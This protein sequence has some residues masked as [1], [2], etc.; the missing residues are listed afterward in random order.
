VLVLLLSACK[1][2]GDDGGQTSARRY[3]AA[4]ESSQT[5]CTMVSPCD[6]AVMTDCAGVTAMLNDAYVGEAAT[7]VESGG[8]GLD[9]LIDARDAV[10]PS[11]A[12]QAFASSFCANCA[13]GVDGCET[14][15]FDT[16]ESD[17]AV[18]GAIILPLGDALV[19]KLQDECTSGLT[20]LATF[21]SCAQGV[22][23]QEAV[24]TET[25]TCV[26][27]GW[28]SGSADASTCG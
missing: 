28:V 3:C 23:A 16:A 19:K 14:T 22:L 4:L 21:S 5:G 13:F 1:G 12:H 27:D 7:C 8:G 24:P 15:L 18:A 25:L 6:Q 26:V 10:A 9:C 2:G 20:C 11:S 17:L